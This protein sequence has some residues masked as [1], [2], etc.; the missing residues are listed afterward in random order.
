M[1]VASRREREIART[2]QD[3]LEAAAR[4]FARNGYQ[5]VTMQEIAKEAG[6]TAASLYSY[7]CS[8]EEILAGL[9][10][11]VLSESHSIFEQPMPAGIPLREKLLLLFERQLEIARKRREI[12][13]LLHL[14]AGTPSDHCEL[15]ANRLRL[16]VDFLE[17]HAR[18]EE[19]GGHSSEDVALM[20]AGAGGAFFVHWLVDPKEGW[21]EERFPHVVDVVLQ[22]LAAA[23]R[24]FSGDS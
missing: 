4:A 19:L 5:A 23:P 15:H 12:A 8:K 17:A 9:R 7:F 24:D 1:T 2:R 13:G 18:P 11:L 10:E 3:I 22:G 21:L 14:G 16:L 20:L 6:Y